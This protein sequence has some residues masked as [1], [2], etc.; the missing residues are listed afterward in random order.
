MLVPHLGL[1]L[2][3]FAPPQADYPTAPVVDTAVEVDAVTIRVVNHNWN[4]MRVY[5]VVEGRR[6][7]L[8]TVSGLA[9]ENL[10][11]RR[12]IV[13]PSAAV[14]FEAV[15]IGHRTAIHAQEFV[16]FE[17]DVLEYRIENAIGLS[18]IRRI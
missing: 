13:G 14:Q 12:S 17:G 6:V 11:L 8:G 2:V 3:A 7:R 1:A 10:K 5:V 15:A 9:T 4:D 18:F 16:V